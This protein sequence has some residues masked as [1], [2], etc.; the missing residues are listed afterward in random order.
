MFPPN[1][2]T[3]ERYQALRSTRKKELVKE[4]DNNK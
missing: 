3:K 4:E 1:G 2:R